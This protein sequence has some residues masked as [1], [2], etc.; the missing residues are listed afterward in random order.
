[1]SADI[2]SMSAALKRIAE[3]DVPRP[4]AVQYMPDKPS[5]HD[6]CAHDVWMYDECAE[7]VADFARAALDTAEL[8]DKWVLAYC[9]IRATA[10][11]EEGDVMQA[12]GWRSRGMD[13]DIHTI[14]GAAALRAFVESEIARKE[15]I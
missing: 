3:L 11:L 12:D 1:M 10:A 14:A 6:K 7:C 5:K 13:K 8:P 9:E 4:V 2:A 15:G